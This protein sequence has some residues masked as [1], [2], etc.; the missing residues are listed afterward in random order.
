MRILNTSELNEIAGATAIV[1]YD[2]NQ[3][4]VTL[5]NPR[6]IFYNSDDNEHFTLY[7]HGNFTHTTRKTVTTPGYIWGSYTSTKWVDSKNKV[8]CSM[9]GTSRLA[10]RRT[11]TWPDRVRCRGQWA[12]RNLSSRMKWRSAT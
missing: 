1:Q 9:N 2:S 5:T 7:G 8:S 11:S 3:L 6:D 10:L 4:I 12:Q